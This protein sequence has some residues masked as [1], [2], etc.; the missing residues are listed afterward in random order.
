MIMDRRRAEDATQGAVRRCN[1]CNRE[2]PLDDFHRDRNL[3]DGRR[4]TCKECAREASRRSF[5]RLNARTDGLYGIFHSMKSRCYVHG[6]KS[7]PRYGGRGIVICD[8][9]LNSFEAF[10]DWA[11]ANGYQPGLQ[12]DRVDNDRGYSPNNCRFVSAAQNQHNSSNTPLMDEDIPCIRSLFRTGR[13]TQAAIAQF[14]GIS[15]STVSRICTNDTWKKESL[16]PSS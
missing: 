8:E 4:Y 11:A 5:Q 9:W 13:K 3:R 7:Y 15:Q 1:C 10:C 16:C 14:F 2:L 6:H 12:I